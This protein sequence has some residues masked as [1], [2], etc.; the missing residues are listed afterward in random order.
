MTLPLVAGVA[1]LFSGSLGTFLA[2]AAGGIVARVLFSLGMG[3]V[4]YVGVT[5]LTNQ[6]VS[7]V[8][9]KLGGVASDVIHLVGLSGFDVFLSLCL[10]AHIGMVAFMMASGGFKRLQFMTDQSGG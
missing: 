10:S 5:S 1:G 9:S 2:A 4:S 8:H 7:T 3:V 6:L